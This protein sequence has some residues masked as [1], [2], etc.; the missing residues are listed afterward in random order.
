MVFIIQAQ[1]VNDGSTITYSTAIVMSKNGGEKYGRAHPRFS[2]NTG[3]IGAC[4]AKRLVSETYD[5]IVALIVA[6]R[7]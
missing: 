3:S 2:A 4:T 6:G 1:F 5:L 7:S